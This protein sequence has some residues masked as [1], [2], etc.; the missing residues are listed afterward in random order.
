MSQ[1][2]QTP[3]LS[4]E[5]IALIKEGSPKPKVEAPVIAPAPE[6]VPEKTIDVALV[7]EKR[8]EESDVSGKE[9]GAT[10]SEAVKAPKAKATREKDLSPMATPSFVSMTFRVPPEI[11]EGL[12]RA[13][14][15]RKLKKVRPATQQEIV[16]E[17]L[18][19]WLKKNGYLK[20]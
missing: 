18:S 6:G 16:A 4:P 14:M 2:L 20:S 19:E 12:L 13:S 15:E 5:A 8:A 7:R 10:S 11:P 3:N 17:A 9:P 1:A